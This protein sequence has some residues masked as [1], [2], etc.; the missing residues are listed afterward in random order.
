[1][2]SISR[3]HLSRSP[4]ALAARAGTAHRRPDFANRPPRAPSP[5]GRSPLS[6]KE[7]RVRESEALSGQSRLSQ[8]FSGERTPPISSSQQRPH[9]RRTRAHLRIWEDP[10]SVSHRGLRQ[11]LHLR[12]FVK[13]RN[14][15]P[16]RARPC[17][18]PVSTRQERRIAWS[19]DA[20]EAL[21]HT[22]TCCHTRP[23]LPPHD[24]RFGARDHV[25]S[26]SLIDPNST[27]D[28][29]AMGPTSCSSGVF[30]PG[31]LLESR[32]SMEILLLSAGTSLG[33]AGQT[34]RR[35]P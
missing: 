12:E 7:P 18:R 35:A 26:R 25:R 3:V 19:H 15:S 1:M 6:H 33:T 24:Q 14:V 23:R 34:G 17:T 5:T 29:Q 13:E 22:H 2:P 32:P 4:C 16:F 11:H 8:R 20:G 9:A 27:L 31:R 21:L 10:G 28:G 30:L